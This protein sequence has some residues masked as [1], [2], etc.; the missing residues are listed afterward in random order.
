MRLNAKNSLELASIVFHV[1]GK[2]WQEI[3]STPATP[4]EEAEIKG[5]FQDY[6]I[7]KE[8]E[9]ECGK[10]FLSKIFSR[11]RVF[12][13]EEIEAAERGAQDHH[14]RMCVRYPRPEI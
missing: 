3:R 5:K 9:E 13:E 11:R 10:G 8:Y 6:K 7:W 4:E 12:T 14:D 1:R 2:S